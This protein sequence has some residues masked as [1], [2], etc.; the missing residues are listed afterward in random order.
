MRD[1]ERDVDAVAGEHA[2]AARPDVV[3]GEDDR[4]RPHVVV[5]SR[6]SRS[7]TARTV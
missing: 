7:S 2:Q 3:V 1:D 5:P 4:R 6:S